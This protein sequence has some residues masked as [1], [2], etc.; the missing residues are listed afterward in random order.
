M[1]QVGP[2]GRRLI[3]IE[4]MLRR[5]SLGN[6]P[7]WLN[8]EKWWDFFTAAALVGAAMCSAC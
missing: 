7:L 4:W 8:I 3:E 2:V 1:E 6:V 5:S